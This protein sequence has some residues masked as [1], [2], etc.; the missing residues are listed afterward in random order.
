[1]YS[2]S[3]GM[4]SNY[5]QLG[6]Y[7]RPVDVRNRDLAVTRLLGVSIAKEF[8]PSIANTVGT[9]MSSYK[10]VRKG[11]FAYGPVTSRNGD[12]ISVALLREEECII[13]QAYTAFEIIDTN[14][15]DPEYLMLWF[16]RPEFD[17]YARFHSH[18]SVRE[19]F[20]W[21]EM[22]RVELPVPDIAK[23]KAIV[24]QINQCSV[25]ISNK[26]ELIAFYEQSLQTLYKSYNFDCDN[27]AEGWER[28]TIG[29]LCQTIGGGTPSTDEPDYYEGGKIPW[30]TPTDV[31][32]NKCLALLSPKGRITDLGLAHSSAKMVPPNTILMTSRASVGF[33]AMCEQEVCTN[34]GFISCI[35]NRPELRMFLLCN[36]IDRVEEIRT[37]ADGGATY[38]EISKKDFRA[39]EVLLPPASLLMD[40]ESKANSIFSLIRSIRQE[41][42]AVKELRT[43][44]LSTL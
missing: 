26:T 37:L 3:L 17:R 43:V 42:E 21:D 30:V 32:R 24:Q 4:K 1:M 15:L 10:V 23:Q 40:F 29:D 18:G 22:C 14:E 16:S 2:R 34:Q 25:F 28:C 19:I 31:T 36:L 35:P 44:I 20:G 5:K 41:I 8:M 7:I 9:D 6:R 12:K 38:S 39:M 27:T 13:S 11:Q 33:F